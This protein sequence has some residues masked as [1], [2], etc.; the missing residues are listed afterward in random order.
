MIALARCRTRRLPGQ[1]AGVGLA[2]LLVT[3]AL[4]SVVL[5][6]VA[7]VYTGALRATR[8]VTVRTST[9][10]DARI[11]MEAMT[12]SL[13]VAVRPKGEAAALTLAQAGTVTF[14]AQLNRTGGATEPLPT[15]VEYSYDGTCIYEATT[16]AR[17]LSSPPPSGPF[18]AW[19][20]GRVSKCLVRTTQAPAF[21][22]YTSGDLTGT[23]LTIG[24]GLDQATRTSVTSV[25]VQLA[26]QAAASTDISPVRVVDRVTL[27]NVLTDSGSTS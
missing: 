22:Y 15:K 21:A 4:L 20:T 13:R 5:A 1:D 16:P 10:A 19:D 26:V 7:T 9:S 8:V 2:E 18:Y 23:A 24:S 11:A 17:V 12:R 14:Y 25:Q 6:A 3:M 27:T